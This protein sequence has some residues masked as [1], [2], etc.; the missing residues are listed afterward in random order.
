MNPLPAAVFLDRDGTII[1]DRHYLSKPED[2]ELVAGAPEAISRIN[3][4]LVPVI[5]ITNQSGIGRG[6]FT[7]EDHL[8]VTRRL[9]EMLNVEGATIDASY[10]CPHAPE[11]GCD[12][13]K[14]GTR[15]FRQAAADYPGI[16]LSRSAYIGDRMRDIEPGLAFGGLAVLVPSAD[17]PPADIERAEKEARIA[18]SLGTALDW[19]LCHN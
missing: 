17:T 11:E 5:V 6:Y 3:A 4:L 15:L 12:C 10:Y 16:D 13:R 19:I 1:A 2:I 18:P 14:P 7:V 8:A 9:D